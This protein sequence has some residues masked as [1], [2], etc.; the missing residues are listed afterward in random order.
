MK[1]HLLSLLALVLGVALGLYALALPAPAPADAAGF[2]A[3]RAFADIEVVARAPHT[4]W[5]PP[6]LVPVRAHI[7]E[8]LTALGLEVSTRRYP[9]VTDVFEHSYPLE[10]I[11]ASLPG[12]SGSSLLLVSHY[13]ASPK[14]R[15]AE[16]EGSRGAADD[17]YGVATMLEIARVLVASKEPRENGVRFL[18]TDAEETGLLGARAEMEQNLGAYGD[19]NF[20]VNLEARGV[21][22]PAVMFETGIGNLATIRLFESARRPFAYSFAVD[23][24]RKMPN[25]TDFTWFVRKGFAG[26]NFAVLDDLSY[27]HTP[28]DNPDNVSLPSLQHYGEQTLPIVQAYARDVAFAG[29]ARF[30]STQDAVYFSWLPGV[31]FAWPSRWD[32]LFA[33]LLAVACFSWAGREIAQGRARLGAS[34]RWL[35]AWLGVAVASLALGLG[36]SVVASKV[37]AIP[38]RL[39]Y[40][41][42][43]PGERPIAWAL[44]LGVAISAYALSARAAV[45]LQEPRVR[46]RSALLGAMALQLLMLAVMMAKLPGGTFLFSTPLFV[47]LA[48]LVAADRARVPRLALVGVVF[49]ASLYVPVLHLFSLALTFGALAI[50]LFL[51]ALPAALVAALACERGASEVDEPARR[52]G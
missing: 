50:L 5:D 36:V 52:A 35:L 25:G 27:Y 24:Y 9:P 34:L 43:V 6:S 18:F 2:S 48:S 10:N 7:R 31:F 1:K 3:H 23:V 42:N 45:A 15:A 30:A 26:L 22:G 41:P 28:R 33:A 32:A 40:M 47:A 44:V 16:Q 38:W 49:A 21:T 51:A 20:V 11:S 17:G 39:T 37:T 4:A 19:V 29:K 13:D 46:D 8:R 12:R 14:K